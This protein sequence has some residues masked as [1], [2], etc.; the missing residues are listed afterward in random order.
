MIVALRHQAIVWINIGF[1]SVKYSGIRLVLLMGGMM[2]MSIIGM[3]ITATTTVF[4]RVK[5]LQWTDAW[6]T[7]MEDNIVPFRIVSG[8]DDQNQIGDMKNKPSAVFFI[9]LDCPKKFVQE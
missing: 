9:N 2:K 3:R 8:M 6:C 1:L 7:L 5:A 4:E